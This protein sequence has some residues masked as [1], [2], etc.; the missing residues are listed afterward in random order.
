MAD[1]RLG[2][3]GR[4]FTVEESE[5]KDR[6]KE[7]GVDRETAV[8]CYFEDME[9]IDPS[10]K[11]TITEV[12]A[13]KGKR[14][15][16]KSDKP[17]KQTVREHKVDEEKKQILQKLMSVVDSDITNVKNEAEFSFNIGANSYTVKLIKHRPPK[18]GS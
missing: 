18:V 8:R 12:V 4:T 16:V 6:M 2:S 13:P 1:F 5:I 10:K 3:N 11:T 9:M 14:R 7:L 17:R 15:Y